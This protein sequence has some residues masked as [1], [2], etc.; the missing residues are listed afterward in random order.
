MLEKIRNIVSPIREVAAVEVL[1]LQDNT[2]VFRLVILK[3]QKSL[4]KTLLIREDIK[5]VDELAD[6]IPS[7]VP[8]AL[9]LNGKGTLLKRISQWEDK[10][11]ALKELLPNADPNDF[12]VSLLRAPNS[13]FSFLTRKE[14]ALE[15]AGKLKEKGCK[16]IDC[17]AGIMLNTSIGFLPDGHFKVS[18]YAFQV[19]DGALI[20]LDPDHSEINQDF[21]I[22]DEK[23]PANAFAAFSLALQ[24]LLEGPSSDFPE[25]SIEYAEWREMKLF[26]LAGL[27]ALSLFGGAVFFNLLLF[28]WFSDENQK[29]S[30]Q[31]RMILAEVKKLETMEKDMTEKEHFLEKAGWLFPS[32]TSWYA[33]RI[34]TSVP[35]AVLL[36]TLELNPLNETA[37]RKEKKTIFNQNIILVAGTCKEPV[38]L[39]PWLKELKSM[40][41]VE[42]AGSRKYEYNHKERIGYFEIEIELKD[43]F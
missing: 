14:K 29:L 20:S 25:A 26:R 38:V 8:L 32:R 21:I 1:F 3:K 9:V 23:V 13:G 7:A 42:K 19:K 37:S 41:W 16:V 4:I 2:P 15:I 18:G 40:E 34:A 28:F 39:N 35:H 5:T 17:R 33:D 36:T 22:G 30:S 10:N 24:L 6:L 12:L 11:K 43:G 27:S 31:N